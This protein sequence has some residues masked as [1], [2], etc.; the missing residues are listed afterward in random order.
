MT[1]E[2]VTVILQALF[3]LSLYAF[4]LLVVR[5]IRRDLRSIPDESPASLPQGTERLVVLERGFAGITQEQVFELRPLTAIGRAPTNDI[6]LQDSY[7]SSEH[8]LLT[9][10]DGIWSVKD[11]DSTNGTY[12]NRLP[13]HGDVQIKHGDVVQ[14]GRTKLKFMRA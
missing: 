7:V 5:I 13:V 11:L 8:A 12:V 6:V 3:V 1:L 4:I 10:K 9:R 14:I 2:V